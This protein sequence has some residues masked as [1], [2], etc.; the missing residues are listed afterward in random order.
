V[1]RVD[2]TARKAVPVAGPAGVWLG[3]LER[4][5]W[6]RNALVGIRTRPD[7]AREVVRLDLDARGARVTGVTN[8]R[9]PLPA[10]GYLSA[11]LSGG[12]LVYLVGGPAAPRTG[13][14]PGRVEFTAY[15]ATLE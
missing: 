5:R 12:E 2:T 15:R 3:G 4:I 14:S 7:G 6:H 11:T 13:G 9:A 1:L 8:V 10:G